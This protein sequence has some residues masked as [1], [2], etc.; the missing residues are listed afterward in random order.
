MKKIWLSVVAVIVAIATIVVVLNRVWIYDFLRGMSYEPS[1]EMALV[2]DRLGLTERGEFL[3]KAS[4]PKLSDREEFNN[5]CRADLD[6]GMAVL[7]CY[8]EGD[9][10][11]YDIT[12]EELAGIRELTAAHELLH[13]VWARMSEDE[14]RALVE[15]LTRTFEANQEFL[16]EEINS[17]DISEKQ[18]E[19]YVRA[20]TEVKDLPA[21]LEEHYGEIFR[22][23]DAMVGFYDSYIGVFRRVEAEMDELR[24]RMD[25]VQGAIGE[26]MVEYEGRVDKL[27]AEIEEFNGCAARA[28]CFNS[29]WEFNSQRR[30]LVAEQESLTEL[31]ERISGLVNEYNGMVEKYNADVLYGQELNR[32]INSAEPADE[33]K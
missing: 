23:Q 4:W 25:E 10:Y 5:R 21:A 28:G 16:E 9:I 19:L 27:N 22:D 1:A 13:A 7:G 18:E 11:V 6:A 29:E 15:P 20:G 8:T 26:L 31:Y 14:R 32:M 17:Y 12:N 2:R 3:F 30:V 33:V 24:A